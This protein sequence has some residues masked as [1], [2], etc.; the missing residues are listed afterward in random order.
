MLRDMVTT[1]M[2]IDTHYVNGN[3]IVNDVMTESSRNLV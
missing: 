3:G 1:S 2:I